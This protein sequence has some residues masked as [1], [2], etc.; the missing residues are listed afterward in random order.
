MRSYP[1]LIPRLRGKILNTRTRKSENP[2]ENTIDHP[3]EVSSEINWESDN[4]LE[5]TADNWRSVGECHWTSLGKCHWKSTMTSEVLISGVRS[6][7]PKA[8]PPVPL[9]PLR[10]LLRCLHLAPAAWPAQGRDIL[11][12]PLVGVSNVGGFLC[13]CDPFTQTLFVFRC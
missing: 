6:F 9:E 5:N 12:F 13:R 10:L 2:L 8:G 1:Y 4:I 11:A 7:A 3:L